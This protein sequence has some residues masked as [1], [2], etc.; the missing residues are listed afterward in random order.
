MDK[1]YN[2]ALS[3][4]VGDFA[5]GGAIRALCDKGYTISEIKERLD[6]PMSKETVAKYVWQHYIDIGRISLALPNHNHEIV[7]Y[8]QDVDT[9]GRKSMRRVVT[10]VP[11]DRQYEICDYGKRKYQDKKTLS[12][13][14]SKIY[15]DKI[16]EHILTLPWPLENV[17]VE[18]GLFANK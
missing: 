8:V 11:N 14:L 4:F 6:F 18:K 10:K 3:N 17:Y 15:E 12:Q 2:Q 1:Y 5:N 9:L 7:E 13:D 16:V